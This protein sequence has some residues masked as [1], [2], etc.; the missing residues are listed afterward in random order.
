MLKTPSEFAAHLQ[1]KQ[2]FDQTA[3]NY[4]QRSRGSVYNFSSLIF[5]RRIAIVEGFIRRSAKLGGKTLDYGM[6][7][8]VFAEC[9]T[10]AGMHYLGIDVSPEMV[11]QSKRLGLSNAEFHVGDLEALSAYK[12]QNDVVLAIGLIDYLENVADGIARLAACVRPGGQLILSFRNRYSVPVLLRNVSKI[13]L[14]P[15]AGGSGHA[16]GKAFFA[17]VHEKSFDLTR[18]LIPHLASLGFSGFEARYFNCSP[19]FFNFP[20]SKSLWRAWYVMDRA[21]AHP[22]TRLLCSGCVVVAKRAD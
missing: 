7:P 19:I 11:E 2:L 1:A 20:L 22:F 6:G 17:K 5:R 18:E 12:D 21:L 14:R 16:S 10:V 4:F 13:I 9:C 15:F 3:D 8:A